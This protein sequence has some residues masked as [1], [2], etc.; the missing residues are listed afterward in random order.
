MAD[1]AEAVSRDTARPELVQAHP[2]LGEGLLNF[3]H[4]PLACAVALGWGGVTIADLAIGFALREDGL[5][6]MK[7]DER[8]PQLPVVTDV[9]GPRFER[10]WLEAVLRASSGS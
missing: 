6:H 4:G 10:A 3:H 5:L 7:P 1:Q 2:A 8:A 9:D